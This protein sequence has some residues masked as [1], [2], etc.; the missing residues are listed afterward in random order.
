MPE[1]GDAESHEAAKPGSMAYPGTSEIPRKDLV[2]ADVMGAQHRARR[3]FTLLRAGAIGVA[4]AAVAGLTLMA[5]GVANADPAPAP[6]PTDG[7]VSTC[8]GGQHPAGLDGEIIIPGP[9]GSGT[10]TDNKLDVTINAG[11]TASGI[12][13]KGGDGANIYFGPFVGPVTIEDMI[14][15]GVGQPGNTPE[16]SHWF[17]CGEE[18]TEETESPGP[19]ESPSESPSDTPSESESTPGTSTSTPP[20]DLPTTGVGLT[21][22]ILTGLALALGGAAAL[23]FFRRKR[24]EDDL[25]GETPAT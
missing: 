22:L 7:N 20:G 2:M 18:T 10:V 15:P 6:S 14:A 25:A 12:V 8:S 21:G 9:G 13:V 3:T 17:V 19:S 1:T 11:F 4:V 5:N 23:F 16:I 24:D